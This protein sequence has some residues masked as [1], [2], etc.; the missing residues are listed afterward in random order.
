MQLGEQVLDAAA[1]RCAPR[2]V[3]G[4]Y[5][6][7]RRRRRDPARGARRRGAGRGAT[8][9]NRRLEGTVD[10][11]EELG[12]EK[13]VHFHIDAA[14]LSARPTRCSASEDE[15]PETLAAGEIGAATATAG[16][17]RVA[18]DSRIAADQRVTFTVDTERLHLFDPRPASD[19]AELTSARSEVEVAA[20][21]DG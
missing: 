6:G 19:W 9:G 16:V 8:A 12:S 13:L 11:V 3:S 7:S 15:E 4:P 20:G 2:R 18:A 21:R 14:R 10:L 5:R 17:A 1:R